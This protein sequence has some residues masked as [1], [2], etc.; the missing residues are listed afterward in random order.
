MHADVPI[1]HLAASQRSLVTHA[2]CAR[3]GLVNQQIELRC[4]DAGWQRVQPRVYMLPSA[5]AD[6]LRPVL[7]AVLSAGGGAAASMHTA[8][9]LHGLTR[10]GRLQP[11][12]ICLPQSHQDQLWDVIVHRTRRLE[13]CDVTEIDGIPATTATRTLIDLAA[14]TDKASLTALVDDAMGLGI[15]NRSWL[16]RRALALRNGRRGVGILVALTSNEAESKFRSWLERRAAYVISEGRVPV[17][18][19]N[20]PIRE[21]ARLLGVADAC[22]PGHRLIAEFDGLR[23]HS[24]PDQRRADAERERELVLAGWRVLRFTW[25]D[26]EQQPET[27]CAALL[28]ALARGVSTESI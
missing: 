7:A 28:R 25:L 24:T 20:E 18:R 27:V 5:P 22:W 21:G 26:V 3:L 23:F 12:Q 14:V 16:H 1:A 4:R 2:D 6:A 19:W 10:V 11:V 15:V 8:A 13:P 9:A 17:P